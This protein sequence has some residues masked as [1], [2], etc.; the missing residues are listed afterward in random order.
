MK[1]RTEQE[2]FH[3]AAI[4]SSALQRR[5]EKIKQLVQ[6]IGLA[7]AGLAPDIKPA[8]LKTMNEQL[9]SL[10]DKQSYE[11]CIYAVLRWV[12]GVTSEIDP[13]NLELGK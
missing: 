10:V 1:I 5:A 9:E 13:T 3:Q 7:N 6:N 8:R 4:S 12:L 11:A 2:I